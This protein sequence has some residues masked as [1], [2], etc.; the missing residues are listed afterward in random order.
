VFERA[1]WKFSLDLGGLEVRGKI[2]RIDRHEATGARRVLDY[3][4]SDT[5]V[6]PPRAHLRAAR[7][8]DDVSPEWMRTA[9]GGRDEVWTDLQLPLYLRALAAEAAGPT[10]CGYFNLPKAVGETAIELWD[11]LTPELLDAAHAC[12]DGVAAAIRAG[13]YWP[14]RELPTERDTFGALFH[15]GAG[16]SVAWEGGR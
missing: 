1:E 9:A 6:P 4:T 2:D 5:A 11:G 8:E 10:A 15:H 7:A 12:A 14:P 3:K 13:D 16:A